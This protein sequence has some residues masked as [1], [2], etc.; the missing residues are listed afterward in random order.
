V[1]P[2]SSSSAPTRLSTSAFGRPFTRGP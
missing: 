1:R 2:I